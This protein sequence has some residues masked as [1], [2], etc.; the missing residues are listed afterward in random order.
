[1]LIIYSVFILEIFSSYIKEKKKNEEIKK[2]KILS[3]KETK[4]NQIKSDDDIFSIDIY[5]FIELIKNILQ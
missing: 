1:M 3:I 4:S 2:R 5:S